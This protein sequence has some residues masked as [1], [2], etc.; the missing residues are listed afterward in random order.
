MKILIADDDA[1]MRQMLKQLIAG[2]AIE[3]CEASDG[4]EAVALYAA[5]RPDWVFMD[6]RMKPMD[7]LHATA[8]IK[9]RFPEAQIVIVSQYDDAE[10]RTEAARAGACAYVLKENLQQLPE[11]VVG[12]CAPTNFNKAEDSVALPPA[13]TKN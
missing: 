2:L 9:A 7:G 11:I 6:W 10:L 12:E 1:R 4:T 13:K 3:V 5:Q 8:Q